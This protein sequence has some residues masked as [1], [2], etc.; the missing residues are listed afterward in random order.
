MT[1]KEGYTRVS[2]ILSMFKD[3]SSIPP[4][5]LENKCRIGTEVHEH[6]DDVFYGIEFPPKPECL[7]YVESFLTWR[8]EAKP[9]VFQHEQRLYCDE[10]KITGQIDAIVSFEGEDTLHIM[11][12]KT[13][14]SEDKL[15][16]PLQAAFYHYLCTN[17]SIKVE[18]VV[19]F[20][21]LDK[22]GKKPKVHE[23][24]IN[25]THIMTIISYIQVY[26]HQKGLLKL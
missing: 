10:L 5:V 15:M 14:H 24:T 17:N 2:E 22:Q 8:A 23:Y 1:I 6:I 20:L 11:D 21:R 26:N 7:G 12:W 13:S 25:P 16:W 9:K 4:D 3:F 18:P 19:K